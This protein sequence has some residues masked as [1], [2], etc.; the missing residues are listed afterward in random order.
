MFGRKH[1]LR[2]EDK[3]AR[4]YRNANVNSLSGS[5][6]KY[7]SLGLFNLG[8]WVAKPIFPKFYRLSQTIMN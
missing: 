1:F 4:K 8:L 2:E 6:C 5:R 3:I 7:N